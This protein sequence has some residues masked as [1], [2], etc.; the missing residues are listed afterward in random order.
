MIKFVA[1]KKKDKVSVYQVVFGLVNG[2]KV[3]LK[4][5][6]VSC[7]SRPT[8]AHLQFALSLADSKNCKRAIFS[9]PQLK[10]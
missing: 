3:G 1:M 10:K 7:Q 8:I 2:Q 9:F 4:T 5:S 6:C